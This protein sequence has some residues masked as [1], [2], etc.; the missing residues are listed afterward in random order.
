MVFDSY[1]NG[2][3]VAWIITSSGAEK[4]IKIWLRKLRCKIE[5]LSPNWEPSGF[6]VDNDS[7]EINALR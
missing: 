6:L 4:D 5:G 2:V 3:P 1:Q 7:A